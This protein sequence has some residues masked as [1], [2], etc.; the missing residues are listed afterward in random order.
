MPMTR[1]A[2]G[3]FIRSFRAH[4][5]A[6]SAAVVFAISAAVFL[7]SDVFAY[8]SVVETVALI[9]ALVA[10]PFWLPASIREERRRNRERLGLCGHCGYDLRATAEK[11]PECGAVPAGQSAPLAG[12]G[13]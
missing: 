2:W 6:G 1:G 9:V 11:C 10:I 4:P 5:V 7:Y 13:G 12:T 8:G 3:R